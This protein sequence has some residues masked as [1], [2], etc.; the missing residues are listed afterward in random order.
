MPL[1]LFNFLPLVFL[2]SVSPGGRRGVFEGAFEV[3]Q[4]WIAPLHCFSWYSNHTVAPQAIKVLNLLNT[5]LLLSLELTWFFCPLVLLLFLSFSYFCLLVPPCLVPF[6][7][8]LFD[9]MHVANCVRTDVVRCFAGWK[10]PQGWCGRKRWLDRGQKVI[11]TTTSCC[12]QVVWL[13]VRLWFVHTWAQVCVWTCV[14]PENQ[15]AHYVIV[16][17]QGSCRIWCIFYTPPS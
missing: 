5:D 15:K 7:S 8:G 14:C 4:S 9:N 12:C 2:L 11:F 1:F 16:W 3:I 17:P 10:W 6:Y 13:Q